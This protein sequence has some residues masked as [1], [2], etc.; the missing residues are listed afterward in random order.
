M[1]MMGGD[2]CGF[3]GRLLEQMEAE[4]HCITE[5]VKMPNEF[6]N[7]RKSIFPLCNLSIFFCDVGKKIG[8]N[9]KISPCE[10]AH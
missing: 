4:R 9:R 8:T 3:P 5:K 10:R 2:N 1:I 7:D 6:E